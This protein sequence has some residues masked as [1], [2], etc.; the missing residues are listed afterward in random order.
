MW[1]YATQVGAVY[2][3]VVVAEIGDGGGEAHRYDGRPGGGVCFNVVVI[4]RDID[5]LRPGS[6]EVAGLGAKA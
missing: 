3:Q 6:G 4:H 5:A 2:L 1:R